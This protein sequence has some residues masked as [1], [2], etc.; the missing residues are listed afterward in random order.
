MTCHPHDT[1]LLP[2]LM[3][4]GLE[5]HVLRGELCNCDKGGAGQGASDQKLNQTDDKRAALS[6][7]YDIIP[8]SHRLCRS[9]AN[10]RA[11]SGRR[12]SANICPPCCLCA[13]S[14]REPWTFRHTTPDSAMTKPAAAFKPIDYPRPDNQLTF[15]LLTNLQVRW[16]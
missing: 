1:G 3:Y 12:K 11:L 13:S 15:D 6:P 16:P 10:P 8:T 2:A 7:A 4:A 9:L 5:S 14:G